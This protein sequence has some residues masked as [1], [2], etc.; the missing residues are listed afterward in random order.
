M[1][2]ARRISSVPPCLNEARFRACG[3]FVEPRVVAV[4]VGDHRAGRLAPDRTRP[5]AP[6]FLA[7]TH[8]G[9]VRSLSLGGRE[10]W[11]TSVSRETTSCP[12]EPMIA[13]LSRSG[14]RIAGENLAAR[15][16]TAGWQGEQKRL[17]AKLWRS[18]RRALLL[19]KRSIWG[20]RY[21]LGQTSPV[22]CCAG[23]RNRRLRVLVGS[24]AV[25]LP[26]VLRR[27][28]PSRRWRAARRGGRASGSPC[29]AAAALVVGM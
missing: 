2:I 1:S 12:N 17:P 27:S 7:E 15:L 21:R 4:E 25:G 8:H 22:S 9:H 5:R 26:S 20:L 18:A 29:G 23:G 3:V 14:W 10:T 16:D 28:W 24:A 13:S 6:L 11:D 19:K